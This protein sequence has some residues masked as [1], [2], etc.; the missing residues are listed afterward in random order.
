LGNN[1]E[2]SSGA[3]STCLRS[4]RTEWNMDWAAV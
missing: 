3:S 4:L 2:G 1:L